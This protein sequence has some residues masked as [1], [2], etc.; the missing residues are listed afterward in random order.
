MNNDGWASD[1]IEDPDA[2][3]PG[4]FE[5]VCVCCN[6]VSHEYGS[7]EVGTMFARGQLACA[8]CTDF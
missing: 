4:R 6:L 7:L 1:P 5:F 3:A 8:T 2:L